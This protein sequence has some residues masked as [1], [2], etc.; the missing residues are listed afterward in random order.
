VCD[1]WGGIA[2]VTQVKVAAFKAPIS[3]PR[4]DFRLAIVACGGE[5]RFARIV[6]MVQNHHGGM[7]GSPQG[8]KL[9][10][11]ALAKTQEQVPGVEKLIIYARHGVWGCR[12]YGGALLSDKRGQFDPGRKADGVGAVS[13]SL[14]IVTLLA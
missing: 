7:S 4:L 9:I 2:G 14:A 10:V 3:L 8:V 5:G 13:S 12:R 6:E 1:R 11:V